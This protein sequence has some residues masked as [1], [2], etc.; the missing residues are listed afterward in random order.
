M[1]K[2]S[3]YVALSLLSVT[4]LLFGMF[5][6]PGVYADEIVTITIDLQTILLD[7]DEVIPLLNTNNIANMSKITISATLP[8]N[9]S[10]VPDLKITAGVLGNTT[11]VIESSSDYASLRGP[12][13]TCYFEDTVD[14][15]TASV[16]AL[17]R[18]FLKNDGTSSVLTGLGTTVTLT[19]IFVNSTSITEPAPESSPDWTEDF[20]DCTSTTDCDGAGEYSMGAGNSIDITND[21]LI[22]QQASTSLGF[23][24][25]MQDADALGSGNNVDDD[26][27]VLRLHGWKTT[28][29]TWNTAMTH[30]VGFSDQSPA[31]IYSGAGDAFG[32]NSFDRTT[33]N[34]G[35]LKIASRDNGTDVRTGTEF[36][37]DL[38]TN[39]YYV[40]MIR[41]NG[42]DFTITF[43]QN[44]D[45]TNIFNQQTGTITGDPTNLRYFTLNAQTFGG[46]HVTQI[47]KVEFWN[48]VS[49]VP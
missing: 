45:F 44:S 5:I 35:I 21:R 12:F 41:S 24:K 14:I 26:D 22:I 1:N 4:V 23:T 7:A 9:S 43:Y 6:F 39:T 18:I 13:D 19:G 40:E 31:V 46:T 25:D 17:N 33:A 32:F 42:T 29:F 3:S 37:T 2:S 11:D 49:S 8:C 20:T 30:S 36:A 47:D 16:P 38:G 10:N 48:G 34:N 27:W 15:D 28:S